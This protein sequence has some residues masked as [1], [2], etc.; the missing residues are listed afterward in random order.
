PIA[1]GPNAVVFGTGR[2]RQ[3]DMMRKGL[4]LNL[5]AAVAL[6]G[7]LTLWM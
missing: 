2:V 5:L 1:T 3:S 7:L 4:L 6:V